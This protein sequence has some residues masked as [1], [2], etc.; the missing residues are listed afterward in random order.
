MAYCQI[1]YHQLIEQQS[2]FLR[3]TLVT[4]HIVLWPSTG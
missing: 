4:I 1:F 3:L 2:S